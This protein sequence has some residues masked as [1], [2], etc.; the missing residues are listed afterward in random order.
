MFK[1]ILLP[2]DGSE[3]SIAAIQQ[4]IRFAKSIGAKV[5]GLYVMPHQQYL[6]YEWTTMPVHMLEQVA[7]RNRELADEYMAVVEKAAKEAGIACDT[8]YEINDSPY[9]AII[10][11]AEK[12]GCDLIM[13]ASHGRRGAGAL[14]IG[15]ETQKV[16]IH[17]KIPVLVYR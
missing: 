3:L 15:S 16:L 1:H 5:T 10:R 17:S 7:A 11:V 4:G 2:T 6:F 13:M 12:T 14:L 8:V 9:D